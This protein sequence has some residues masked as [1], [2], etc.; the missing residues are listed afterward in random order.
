VINR[1][2]LLCLGLVLGAAIT[3]WF[4]RLPTG[5]APARSP[6]VSAQASADGDDEATPRV[7]VR[8]DGADVHVVLTPEELAV[9]GIV[10]APT[11]RGS[12]RR[13]DRSV[14]RVADPSG[15]FAG[16]RELAAAGSA[17]AA[18]RATAGTLEAR[19]RHLRE[20]V[21]RGEI[22]ATRELA[23]LELER[24]RAQE[25]VAASAARVDSARTALRVAW[26]PELATLAERA[27]ERLAPL[28]EGRRRLVEFA[29]SE[30]PPDTVYATTGEDREHAVAVE[31]L[32][33]AAAVLGSVQSASFLG[34]A[35][36]DGLRAGMRLEVFVP[37]SGAAIEGEVLP[38]GAVVWHRGEAWYF[39]VA[40]P[41]D[42]L[43]RPLGGAQPH[44]AGWLL[45]GEGGPAREV[46]LQGAQ[47]LLAEANREQ[48]PEE[49]DD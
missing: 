40:G 11:G 5:A 43:R 33:P 20:L 7:R 3:L 41:G 36:S 22:A 31:V 19:L 48:I 1:L 34:L 38:A 4:A 24:R 35:P 37:R 49:D 29:A 17:A 44:P 30:A 23:D 8:R 27:P 18:Q 21:A 6:A 25:S 28:E 2:L 47:A 13:E 12:V 15:L 45:T 42:F 46:V 9:A 14:G 32:G 10:T 16:L 26:G 39:A